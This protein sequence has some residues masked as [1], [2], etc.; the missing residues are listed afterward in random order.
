MAADLRTRATAFLK[1]PVPLG[2]SYAPASI[3]ETLIAAYA[4]GSLGR[5]PE[6]EELL[7][8]CVQESLSTAEE[9]SGEAAAFFHENAE[10][11]R[12]IHRELFP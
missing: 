9:N 4:G 3:A 12:A 10:I 11:L 7:E 1:R 2:I 8:M 6:V 5:D